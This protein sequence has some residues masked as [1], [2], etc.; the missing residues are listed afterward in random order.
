MLIGVFAKTFA[1][2]TPAKVMADAAAAAFKSVQYNMACSGLS[3]LPEE[4]G[5]E[6][7]QAVAGASKQTGIS[8][9]AISATYNMAHPSGAVR[10]A[11]RK[12]F[13]VIAAKAHAVGSNL[14]TL[15]TGSRDPHDQWRHHEQNNTSDAWGDM[16]QEFG[17]LIA[18]AEREDIYLGIEP[19]LGNVVSTPAK[20]AALIK[21]M[22]SK[23]L[24]IVFD[25]ANLFEIAKAPDVRKLIEQGIERLS[26]HIGLAHAKDRD[27]R[28]KPCAPGQGVIDFE[29]Y[30]K[31][32]KAAG[33]TGDIIAHG[34][35]AKDASGVA[36]LL[37][38]FA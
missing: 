16:V 36:G 23:R 8:V 25:A 26:G 19:E 1:G 28:G 6:V 10:K 37:K 38:S 24:R 17:H 18:I 33:F 13:A 3:A 7:V 22:Q 12:S 4:I 31:T 20:A 29:H 35:E 14:L 21:E 27:A 11:G 34:F 15:C 2:T 32:L 5:D 30:F 9:S